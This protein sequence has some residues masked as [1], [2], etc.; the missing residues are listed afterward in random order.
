VTVVNGFVIF[1]YLR[2]DRAI[3][4]HHIEIQNPQLIEKLPLREY[5]M[6]DTKYVC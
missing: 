6:D 4:M 3:E 2:Q 1:L 5:P